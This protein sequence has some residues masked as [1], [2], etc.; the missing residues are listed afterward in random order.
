MENTSV[1]KYIFMG[2]T[3]ILQI[4]SFRNNLRIW[5]LPNEATDWNISENF[6]CLMFAAI[7]LS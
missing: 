5:T 2:N 6:L 7:V 3:E 4:L 1:S